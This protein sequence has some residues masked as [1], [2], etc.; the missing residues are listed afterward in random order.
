MRR[1]D[2]S[3]LEEEEE[4]DYLDEERPPHR[5]KPAEGGDMAK[6]CLLESLSNIVSNF[7]CL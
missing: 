4:E 3:D 2:D 5:S 1:I 6:V 7:F